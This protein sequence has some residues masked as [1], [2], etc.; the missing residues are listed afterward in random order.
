M[1]ACP[2]PPPA[3]PVL[4]GVLARALAPRARLSVSAWA[5]ANRVLSS[6]GSAEPG[7]WRTTRNPLQR[8]IMDALSLHSPVQ[9]VVC[10]LPIQWGKTEIAL[11]WLGY[12]LDHA[13][14]PVM[15]CLPGEVSRDKWVAQK[16]GPMLEETPACRE[17][18]TSTATRDSANQRNFKD[19][20]GGQLYLEHAGNPQRLKSTTVRWLIADEL[21]EFA[22][23]TRAGD[24]PVTMLEGRTSAFPSSYKRL[25][26]S[27]PGIKGLSRIDDLYRKGDQ[28]RFH[29]PCPHCGHMQ[30]LEW[31]GMTWA[32]DGSRCWYACADCG[33]AIDEHHKPEMLA[34]GRWV[35]GNPDATV[36][37]YHV[38][39]LYYPLGL[40]PRWSALVA[41]W[42]EAQG[43]QAK[44]KTFI[45]DRLAEPW[46]DPAMRQVRH[47]AIA[48]RAEPYRL[49]TAPLGVLAVTAGVDTQD[50]RLEVQIIGWGRGLSA[51]TL[52]YAVLPGDPVDE[53]VWLALIDLLDRPLEH[54]GGQPLRVEAMAI[55]A[56]GHRTHDVYNFVRSRRL[57]RAMAIFGASQANAPVISRGK[58]VDVNWRGQLDRRGVTIHHVGT[59]AI[60][61]LL[62]SRLGA[63]AERPPE[64]RQ[65][66]LSDELPPEFF[67]GL[68]A[69][70]FNP[71]KG[72]FQRRKGAGR[73]EVLDTWV[74]A[75]AAAHHP[76]LRLHRHTERDWQQRE[77]RLL[78]PAGVGQGAAAPAVD[79]P[80][81]TK[82]AAPASDDAPRPASTGRGWVGSKTGRGWGR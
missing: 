46:E 2:T 24:D 41:Q 47:D 14:G 75:Y 4:A 12:I 20:A 34:R 60:K 63:D 42:R 36:R 21:D 30:P 8:E 58:L 49:R 38:N 74:Y 79:V 71:A 44:L 68:V 72:T 45:N 29:V 61:H 52:D 33:T 69:E 16:L 78:L 13:P 80:R 39:A 73:N 48:D 77:S 5:D 82:P 54:A 56:G 26:I 1:I 35:A 70:V 32:P 22:A 59:V 76:E 64:A 18:L 27:T 11:N 65:V 7:P 19:F 81:E 3:A 37:S 53:A 15:V 6:K 28:R 55:D 51:W 31:S 23:N 25:Y 40:G 10:M 17:A 67:R 62:Y 9:D 43:D 50:D 57:R 66:R